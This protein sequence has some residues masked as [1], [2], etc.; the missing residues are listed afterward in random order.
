MTYPHEGPQMK[1]RGLVKTIK[2]NA[3]ERGG[4]A[5]FVEGRNHTKV[6][7]GGRHTTIPRHNEVNELTAHGILKYLFPD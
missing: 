6:T 3:R 1:Y 2:K 4:M 5:E 7:V